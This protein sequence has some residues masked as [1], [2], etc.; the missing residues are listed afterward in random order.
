MRKWHLSNQSEIPDSAN[1]PG[2][3]AAFSFGCWIVCGSSSTGAHTRTALN[4]IVVVQ[5]CFLCF[6][7]HS[8]CCNFVISIV[9][10]L[11][12]IELQQTKPHTQLNQEVCH[13]LF[14]F[15]LLHAPKVN[16]RRR[17]QLTATI[18]LSPAIRL[19]VVRRTCKNEQN[20]H[21]E[22]NQHNI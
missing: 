1:L 13:F 10:T 8:Q 20:T 6:C 17:R 21:C 3:P 11:V 12:Q 16:E 4:R 15:L 9:T 18:R 7:C 22:N 5:T 14:V 2:R 19:V